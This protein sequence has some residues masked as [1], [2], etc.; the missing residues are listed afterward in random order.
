MEG[1]EREG[2]YPKE[3]EELRRSAMRR[4]REAS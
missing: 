4:E 2:R 1:F 3:D